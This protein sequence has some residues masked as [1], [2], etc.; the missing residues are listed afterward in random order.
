MQR[1]VLKEQPMPTNS[2]MDWAKLS[3]SELK[4]LNRSILWSEDTGDKLKTHNWCCEC[5]ALH[6]QQS[7]VH[8]LRQRKSI[9]VDFVLTTQRNRSKES[10]EVT[11]YAAVKQQL[12]LK[13]HSRSPVTMLLR[14]LRSL[15]QLLNTT[16]Q[17]DSGRHMTLL[18]LRLQQNKWTAKVTLDSLLRLCPVVFCPPH[19][20]ECW[21]VRIA[22]QI[23]CKNTQ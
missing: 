16:P 23:Q 19:Q 4:R 7:T 22:L 2:K 12:L 6:C 15:V 14:G 13:R 3:C 9:L 17:P 10:L 11:S 8:S 20:C 5:K 18:S 1:F 21:R